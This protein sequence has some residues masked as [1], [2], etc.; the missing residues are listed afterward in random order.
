MGCQARPFGGQ[1]D[2]PPDAFQQ[3]HTGF[4][5]Q[6]R[7]LLRY[8]RGGEPEGG[9]DGGHGSAMGE[10]A[11]EPQAGEVKHQADLTE[12]VRSLK[13]NCEIAGASFA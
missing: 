4:P 2:P 3:R 5:L 6:D 11:E 1:A 8:S 7:E 13:W 12:I 9:G 10:L